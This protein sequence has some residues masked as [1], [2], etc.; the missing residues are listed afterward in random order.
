MRANRV[1]AA[2]NWNR[3]PC[4]WRMTILPSGSTPSSL[5]DV[6]SG[7][8]GRV[9]VTAR[10]RWQSVDIVDENKEWLE[11]LVGDGFAARDCILDGCGNE[12]RRG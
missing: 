11:S 2:A 5:G 4:L 10:N 7:V 8:V 9:W 12:V 3:I 6:C 1:V